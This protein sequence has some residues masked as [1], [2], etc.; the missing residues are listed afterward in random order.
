METECD[1][2]FQKAMLQRVASRDLVSLESSR[3]SVE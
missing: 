2:L 1:A 3:E